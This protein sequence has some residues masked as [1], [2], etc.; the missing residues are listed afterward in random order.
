[1]TDTSN[2]GASS[3]RPQDEMLPFLNNFHDIFTTIGVLILLGGLVAGIVQVMGNLGGSPEELAWQGVLVALIAGVGV[4]AWLLSSVLVGWQRRVLPGIV[5]SLAFLISAAG[6]LIW[7]YLRFLFDGAGVMNEAF[8]ESYAASVAGIFEDAEI[9][10]EAVLAAANELPWSLRS[11]PIVM[12]LAVFIPIA[13]YYSSFRL[14]FAGGLAGAA[15][16]DLAST[17]YFVMDPYTAVMNLPSIIVASGAALLLAGIIFDARDPDRT[18]RLSGTA[19]WLHLFAAPTLLFGVLMV[20]QTGWTFDPA[21]FA[22]GSGETQLEAMFDN[23]AAGVGVAITSLIVIG[24]FALVSL[25]INRRALIVSGLLTA[26][27][28]IAVLVGQFGL[29]VGAVVTATLLLLGGGVVFLGAAWDP[30][31]RIILAPF[32]N[33]GPIARIFPPA[34][35]V[36]G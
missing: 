11:A 31:R 19:F 22:D 32:P 28:S 26:G 10:R 12:S 13:A 7:A 24:A 25:L 36:V 4:L 16:V 14:P 27:V 9:G 17:T 20:T 3:A 29:G 5:L 34:T 35:G 30:V 6:V 33:G 2:S 1:M 15:L 18:T 23:E 8:F 21:A